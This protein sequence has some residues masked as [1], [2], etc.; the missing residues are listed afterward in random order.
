MLEKVNPLGMTYSRKRS[1]RNHV[2]LPALHHGRA[3]ARASYLINVPEPLADVLKALGVGDVVHEHDSHGTPV[4]GC[5]DGVEPLLSC[6]IPVPRG[7]ERE[8]NT[9]ML[10]H[11]CR[12]LSSNTS[13]ANAVYNGN[14]Y[15]Y[16]YTP[17]LLTI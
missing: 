1:R 4:V 15:G 9:P 3:R 17:C 11:V 8:T 12:V 7:F 10:I 2:P 13:C 16:M 6:S 5:G 14:V